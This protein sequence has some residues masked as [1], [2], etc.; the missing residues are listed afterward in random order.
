MRSVAARPDAP[1]G[2]REGLRA[3]AVSLVG[4]ALTAAV[5][6]GVVVA[7]GS[8]ALLGDTLH[9]LADALTAVP[10]GVAFVLGRRPPDRR[11]TYGYG[12]AE[13]V[14]AVLVVLAIAGSAVAAGYESVT[15]L[16]HPRPVEHLW[17]VFAAGL[18]G[19][20][21]NE[22]VAGY[23]IRVGRRIGSAALVADGRH[24]RADGLT[25]LAVVAGAVGTA[26]GSER[27][28]PVAGLV[29]TVAIVAV[30]R[31][32]IR[33]VL[34]RLMDAVDPRL[35][36]EVER[37]LSTV[38]GVEEVGRVRLRW[39]GHRLHAE[40]DVTVDEDLTVRAAH[41]IAEAAR[42]ELL[43]RVRWL[44]SATVHTDP[45][46][47]GG[48]DPHAAVSHHDAGRDAPRGGHHV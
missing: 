39:I 35:V 26:A 33:D 47:H 20:A 5:Q 9:N 27:A 24:A 16:A 23:R 10:L 14:A 13:D 15:R 11:H 37:A 48:G 1:D 42:H 38:G 31:E 3:L 21:G 30:L 43:H 17:A 4:L 40:V 25:S 2:G 41:A 19:F 18:A 6:A 8:V 12:R 36:A 34:P 28:D 44:A 46:G 29:V 22:A 32:A 7:T 45:C